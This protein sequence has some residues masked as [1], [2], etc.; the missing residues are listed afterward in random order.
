MHAIDIIS[1]IKF[2]S[3]DIYNDSVETIMEPRDLELE[4]YA[5]KR[6]K[7]IY[8]EFLSK[9]PTTLEED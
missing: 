4:L 5:F 8:E 2:L 1:L 6:V 9:L 7:I 3:A